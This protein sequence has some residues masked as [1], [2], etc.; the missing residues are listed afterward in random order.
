MGASVY[1]RIKGVKDCKVPQTDC[2]ANFE[3]Y[4]QYY[5]K[6]LTQGLVLSAHDLS[7]GGLAVAAAEMAFSCKGGISIDLDKLPT[8]GGWQNNAVPCFSESTGRFL[9]EVDED[10]AEDFAAA[11]AGTPCARIGTATTDGQLTITAKGS[12]VLQAE[13]AELKSIWKNGLTP[14]Y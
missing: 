9:V 13:I 1:A 3:V 8:N 5:A 11:M 4:K 12:T 2:A 7:E 14:F 6:A 10:L